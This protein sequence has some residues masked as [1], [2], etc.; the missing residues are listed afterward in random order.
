MTPEIAARLLS[1]NR[2]FYASLADPFAETRATPQP[3]FAR[4]L[5]YLPEPCRSVL[6]V[7]CGEGRYGRFLYDQDVLPTRYVGIDFTPDLLDKAAASLDGT[8]HVRDI[9]RAGCVEGL[10]QF[11]LVVCL[12]TLQHVPGQA[13]RAR[14]LRE[15]GERLER[16][17]RIFLSNWQFMDSARQRR[18]LRPWSTIGL[19]PDDLEPNDYLLTWQRGGFGLRYVCHIDAAATAVL[20]TSAGLRIVAQFRSDGREGDLNLYTVLTPSTGS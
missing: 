11:D 1:L 20:A 15:M 6:D 12:A 5:D 8:F 10:G 7:G 9:T 13:G 18:K 14:L 16:N 17:G 2:D 19:Q 4:L 3:G